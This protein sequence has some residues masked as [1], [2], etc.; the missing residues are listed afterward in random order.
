MNLPST[1]RVYKP[2]RQGRRSHEWCEEKG[3]GGAR[4]AQ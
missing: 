2:D 4:Q 3:E 1:W